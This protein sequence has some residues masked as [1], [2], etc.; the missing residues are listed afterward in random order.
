MEN[1]NN[2]FPILEYDEDDSM[3]SPV[4]REELRYDLNG[5]DLAVMT[6]YP[7]LHHEPI[8]KEFTLLHNF[9]AGATYVPQYVYKDSI[10]VA[11]V[12]AGGAIAAQLMEELISIGIRRFIACGS[13]GLLCKH[14][15]ANNLL[16]VTEAIRDEGLSYQYLPAGESTYTD[17]LLRAQFAESLERQGVAFEEGM[18]WSTDALYRETRSRVLRREAMGAIAVDM[19]CASLCAVAQRRGVEFAQAVYFRNSLSTDVW[20]GLTPNYDQ[21]RRRS[22][23]ILLKTGMDLKDMF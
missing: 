6:F 13:A 11:N 19:E 17:A 14:F 21:L 12:P 4:P 10:V 2:L 5:I 1:F 18:I 22:L 23:D 16:L 7:N 8:A 15:D 9:I 3:I 20:S